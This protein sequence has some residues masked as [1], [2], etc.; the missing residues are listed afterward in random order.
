MITSHVYKN[1]LGKNSMAHLGLKDDELEKESKELNTFMFQN[2]MNLEP[3]LSYPMTITYGPSGKKKCFNTADE[4]FEWLKD[5]KDAIKV[6]RE[7]GDVKAIA[8][9]FNM[10]IMVM[11]INREGKLELPIQEYKPDEEYKW[12]DD[13]ETSK[14]SRPMMI[15]IN[16]SD[17]FALVVKNEPDE[18]SKID[19]KDSK[20]ADENKS[21]IEQT[22]IAELKR[23]I[24]ELKDA[25]K[26][27]NCKCKENKDTV[28][29]EEGFHKSPSPSNTS[30]DESPQGPKK[31]KQ[32]Y[33]EKWQCNMCNNRFTTSPLLK[34]HMENK[35]GQQKEAG[36]IK[37][38]KLSSCDKCGAIF[39]TLELLKEHQLISHKDDVEMFDGN[40]TLEESDL[41]DMDIE[42]KN[43]EGKFKCKVCK[44]IQNT[45][46]KLETH[47]KN[48]TDDADWICDGDPSGEECSY[49]SNNRKHLE[50]H[51]KE[52]GH[53]SEMLRISDTE[54]ALSST[55]TQQP[56]IQLIQKNET[57]KKCP[58]C[59]L[60][61]NSNTTMAQHRRENHPTSKPCRNIDQ[62]KFGIDCFYSHIPIPEGYYRCFQCGEE[63]ESLN[64][65]MLHRKGNHDSV[66]ICKK[67]VENKCTKGPE[68]WWLHE[69]EDFHQAPENPAPP[70]S[71]WTI[72][73]LN[74]M[75]NQIPRLTN[76]TIMKMMTSLQE[77]MNTMKMFLEQLNQNQQ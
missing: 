31:T 66:K 42:D 26:S 23:E 12:E 53:I 55:D 62:C 34:R 58:F 47:M 59:E 36:P 20:D 46:S 40:N 37:F 13:K 33:V 48:H 49:Q 67:F 45:K 73:T 65:M 61:F 63:F 54:Q 11:R 72:P 30:M 15:L 21:K 14:E 4:H 43:K 6:W 27:Q 7:C 39:T 29:E 52:K 2:Q 74:P 71:V 77:T 70:E 32:K 10:D 68:C 76:S 5:D 50:N 64:H 44:L 38:S 51:I 56:L 35:H 22:T 24:Q 16:K 9:K 69:T 75:R 60:E 28:Q 18:S 17:H 25:V 19:D 57:K 41:E 1:G 3:K 8:N